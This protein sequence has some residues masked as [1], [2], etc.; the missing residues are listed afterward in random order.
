MQKLS[1]AFNLVEMCISSDNFLRNETNSEDL[2]TNCQLEVDE[3][4][5]LEKAETDGCREQIT[6][7][8]EFHKHDKNHDENDL[9]KCHEC[10]QT[11]EK[12]LQLNVH[13]RSHIKEEDK[14][15]S[16]KIC[17]KLFMYEYLLKQHEYKHSD[18]KPYPCKV[19]NKGST[20]NICRTSIYKG[21]FRM[22]YC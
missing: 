12:K 20:W 14:K 22:P 16:C 15:F 6:D 11:F 9:F 18:A 4:E 2:K 1:T 7:E 17:N 19:C 21:V 3:N 13:L 5:I 8:I 10:S